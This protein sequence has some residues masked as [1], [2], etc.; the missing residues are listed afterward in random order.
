[1]KQ[2]DDIL[3][4]TDIYVYVQGLLGH[5]INKNKKHQSKTTQ[6]II[7][8][9]MVHFTDGCRLEKDDQS[10]SLQHILKNM[11]FLFFSPKFMYVILTC[12]VHIA[13]HDS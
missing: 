11:C 3:S 5:L 7:Y 4:N 10:S 13:I 12:T 2:D 8:D 9:K 6:S 1:M